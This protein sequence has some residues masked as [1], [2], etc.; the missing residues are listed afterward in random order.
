MPLNKLKKNLRDSAGGGGL[1]PSSRT[2]GDGI[3]RVRMWLSLLGPVHVESEG[4]PLPVA[5]PK[6]RA[7]LAALAVSA[8]NV[9]DA[10][11]I[12]KAMWGSAPPPSQEDT[13]RTYVH[14]LRKSLGPLGKQR[15]V[16]QPPGYILRIDPADLDIL[17]FESLVRQGRAAVDAGNWPIAAALLTEA[18]SLWRGTPLADIPLRHLYDR[19][20][21]YL[22]QTRLTAQELRIEADIRASRHGSATTIPQLQVLAAQHPERERLC[23]LLMLACFRSGRQTEALA[24]Y[25]AARDLSVTEYA[26]EPGPDLVEMQKRILAQDASLLAERLDRFACA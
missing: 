2:W 15:I 23:L 7:L 25:S 19:Y 9:V 8:N 10:D 1:A 24:A 5:A 13:I 20:I 16:V 26:V 11:R 12:A 4:T 21:S 6:H 22:E 17:K 3:V 18:E 14:R